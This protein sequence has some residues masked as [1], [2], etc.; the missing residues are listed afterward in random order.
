[1]KLW[2]DDQLDKEIEE[3]TSGQDKKLDE[4]LIGFDIS[5][6]WVHVAMLHKVGLLNQKEKEQLQKGLKELAYQNKQGLLKIEEEDSHTQIEKYLIEKFG[7]VGKKVHTGRSRNDQVLTAIRLYEKFELLN[8]KLKI[9]PW[10]NVLKEIIK[11]QGTIKIPGYT[12][13]QKAMPTTVDIWAG[14]FVDA[15][16]DDLHMLKSVKELIDQ[17][18]LGSAAAFGV[19]VLNINKK[20]TAKK[21]GFKKVQNNPLYCQMSRGKFEATVLHLLSSIMFTINKFASDLMMFTMAEFN[22]VELPASM[23]TGSSIMPQKK[24]ADVLELMRGYYHVV[25]GEQF[26]VQSLIGDLISGYNRDI[27]LTKEPVIKSFEIVEK[28]LNMAYKV[29]KGVSFNKKDCENSITEDMLAT[30]EV[31]KLVQQGIPFREAYMKVAK[32]YNK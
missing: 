28:C 21:L 14:Q 25:L 30:E 8:L 27:Q 20:F 11:K 9:K 26:K 18:P 1:M 24:N 6:T 22:Y 32:K 29:T 31:Y 13:M 3:F 17:N 5:A 16:E 15:L 7:D 10:Q 23:T 2:K 19:P 4:K 12:H